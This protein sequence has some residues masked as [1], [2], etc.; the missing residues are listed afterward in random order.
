MDFTPHSI[1]Q[2]QAIFSDKKI[3]AL[4]TGIQFGKTT[5]GAMRMA[6][7]MHRYTDPEDAFIICA[8]TYKI[9]QQS[10]L[11]AFL[12]LMEGL[13]EY[14]K[15]DAVFRIHGGGICYFRTAT[16]PDS[17][18]GITNVRWVWVDEAGKV[19]LYFW[20]NVQAR[21]AFLNCPIDLTSS[22]YSLNWLFKEIVRPKQKNPEAHPNVDLIQAASW[23]NPYFPVA[24]I[25][26]AKR[27][28]DARR[29]NA[30]FG[31]IW[32]R[33]AGLVYDCF[34]EDENICQPVALPPG[35]R[36]YAGV[37]W[38]YS[39]PFVLVVRAVTPA[40]NHFQVSEVYKS[41]LTITDIVRICGE[42]KSVYN[43]ERYYC[44]PSQPGH[45]EELSRNG[46]PAVPANNDIRLGVDK[47]YE[48]IKTRAY[49]VFAGTSPYTLDEYDTYHYPQPDEV[50]ADQ[51]TKDQKPV[52][53]NDHSMDAN[54][55]CT[56]GTVAM[57][58]N[59]KSPTV[60][61]ENKVKTQYDRLEQL[62]KKKV[63]GNQTENWS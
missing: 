14:N 60:P 36:F 5:V 34:S 15:V 1:K 29:F 35:T 58:A 2:E 26:Q 31:G 21:A 20:E 23:E 19:S 44:D 46:I 56:M 40:G 48:L 8:P 55:Y 13:G 61:G 50:D 33:I 11:P 17:I 25:E 62:R 10:T 28:M 53:Q 27:T 30:L 6:M 3:L 7:A 32:E 38:G 52:G 49:K 24:S 9:L 43:I 39:E 42:K 51:A 18:V 22:P 47:H 41:G 16:E 45:I 63:H 37:D 12:K 54:R 59:K 4:L 57:G